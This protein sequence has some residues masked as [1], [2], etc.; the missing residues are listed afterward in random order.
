M[1]HPDEDLADH[2]QPDVPHAARMWNYR[3]GARTTSPPTGPPGTRWH[4]SIAH[5]R[6]LLADT[7][8]DGVATYVQ[9]DYHDPERI[10][11]EAAKTLD[12][13]KPVAVIFMGMRGYEPDLD[14]VRSIVRRM[15]GETAPGS[16]PVLWDGTN[17]TPAVVEG[18]EKLAQ[19][20]GVR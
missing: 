19:S 13:S 12:L 14:P 3:M 4:R 8:A 6:A 9:A 17:T 18:A 5:A 10:L 16:R 2:L 20:G 11:A 7:T 1:T 15:V